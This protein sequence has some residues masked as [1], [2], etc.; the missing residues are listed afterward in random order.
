MRARTG[1]LPGRGAGVPKRGWL[2]CAPARL[3]TGR[4]RG[5]GAGAHA[6]FPQDGLLDHLAMTGQLTPDIMTDIAHQMARFH[7]T[8]GRGP[9]IDQFGSVESVRTPVVQNFSQTAPTSAAR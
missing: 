9:E 1:L 4:D 8:T 3:R 5:R 7:A 2:S 6:P